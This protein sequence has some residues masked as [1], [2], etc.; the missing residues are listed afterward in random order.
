MPSNEKGV[1][2]MLN[3]GMETILAIGDK[4]D[5]DEK[6]QAIRGTV[7]RLISNWI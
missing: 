4:I 7:D 2:M 5:P 3:T 1:V 6:N